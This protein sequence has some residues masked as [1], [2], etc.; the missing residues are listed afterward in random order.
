M[1]E[2]RRELVAIRGE[3]DSVEPGSADEFPVEIGG[4]VGDRSQRTVDGRL[5]PGGRPVD[6]SEYRAGYPGRYGRLQRPGVRLLAAP[7]A[8]PPEHSVEKVLSRRTL[9]AVRITQR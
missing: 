8:E 4:G 1:A 9:H 2:R 6:V 5:E 7:R 3:I